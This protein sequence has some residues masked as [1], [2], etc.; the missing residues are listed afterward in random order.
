MKITKS[1]IDQYLSAHPVNDHERVTAAMEPDCKAVVTIPLYA[2]SDNLLPMLQSFA[3]QRDVAMDEFE[4]LLIV[5]NDAKAVERMSDAFVDNLKTL[6][7][8][9]QLKSGEP[10]EYSYADDEDIVEEIRASGL[11]YYWVDA[12]S[13]AKARKNNNVGVARELGCKIAASRL[14]EIGQTDGLIVITDG[15]VEAYP[16]M[17]AQVL[18]TF[19]KKPEL[20]GAIGKQHCYYPQHDELAVRVKA[21]FDIERTLQAIWRQIRPDW[22]VPQ[23]PKVIE[24]IMYEES[25]AVVRASAW[26]AVGGFPELPGGA[27]YLFGY[28]LAQLGPV[29]YIDATVLYPMRASQRTGVHDGIGWQVVRAEEAV[30]NSPVMRRGYSFYHNHGIIIRALRE[31]LTYSD[32]SKQNLKIAKYLDEKLYSTL[33][34]KSKTAD[35]FAADLVGY[36]DFRN[37]MLER[38]Y[39][40]IDKATQKQRIDKA[41]YEIAELGISTGIFTNDQLKSVDERVAGRLQIKSRVIATALEIANSDNCEA[42]FR[43]LLATDLKLL[44]RLVPKDGIEYLV[45]SFCKYHESVEL[46][47]LEIGLTYQIPELVLSNELLAAYV[48]A[49]EI[50]PLIT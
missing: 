6:R 2:E 30:L 34:E 47:L 23:L 12:A 31:R 18:A 29:D 26:A 49:K 25:C 35:G 15:D 7:M 42:E 24:D 44:V 5:N 4:I 21:W 46:T 32:F 48:L 40:I 11:V 16:N 17:I 8:L 9:S 45:E 13:A 50:E 41:I 33:L 1:Q 27:G 37:V 36:V 43:K 39:P 3:R 22:A 38:I 28:R 14:A 19:E 20:V 10:V